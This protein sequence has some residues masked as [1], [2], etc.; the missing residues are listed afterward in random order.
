MPHPL[1]AQ[2]L[3]KFGGREGPSQCI[4]LDTGSSSIQGVKLRRADG[5]PE[6]LQAEA[7]VFPPGSDAA[8]R[9]ETI[10]QVAEKLGFPET[11]LVACVGG[12]GT[13]LRRVVFPKMTR[14]ELRS[15]L[16]FEAEKYIPFKLNEIFFDFSILGD[17]AGGQ[18]EVLLAAARKELVNEL[19]DL[20][21]PLGMPL[22]VGL[23]MGALANAWEAAPVAGEGVTGL[24]HIGGRG[25]VLDFLRD[26]Q[27]EFAREIPVGGSEFA[28][29]PPGSQ[30]AWE[31]WLSQCRVSF[32]FYENEF[33]RRVERLVLSGEAARLQGFKEWVQESSGLPV[34]IWDPFS[35]GPSYAVAIG[36]A[37]QGA[38]A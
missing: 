26:S 35:Q 25:T 13:V 27:M 10:R 22:A 23:E 36:L 33:G 37:L 24:L 20:L 9:G 14:E 16:T 1:I 30:A 11:P 8:R 3:S 18:M 2:L 5:Q 21:S 29:A 19:L 32:D 38:A 12:P 17:R 28:Q 6:V 7:A 31:E 34:Q 4:G 15:A